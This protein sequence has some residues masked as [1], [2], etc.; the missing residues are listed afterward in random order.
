LLA[1]VWEE[2]NRQRTTGHCPVAPKIHYTR[3]EAYR[4]LQWEIHQMENQIRAYKEERNLEL[5]KKQASSA[6]GVPNPASNT[7]C[8]FS[9]AA[10]VCDI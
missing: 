3:E 7:A 10:W 5:S 1:K 9:V 8:P 4:S 2:S 6:T